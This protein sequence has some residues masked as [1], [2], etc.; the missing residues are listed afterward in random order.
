MRILPIIMKFAPNWTKNKAMVDEE[1]VLTAEN[2][3]VSYGGKVAISKINFALPRGKILAVVGESGS[4]KSTLLKAVQGLLG[5]A[6]RITSGRIVFMG[7]DI[8][9]LTDDQRRKLAGSAGMTMIFQNAAASFCPIRTVNEQIFEAVRVHKDWNY[10]HFREKA[11]GIAKKI[12]LKDE[13]LDEYPFRL[14]GGM[15]QRAGILAAII[16]SPKLILA[17]EPTS[18]L[19]TVTQVSVAKE[20]LGLKENLGISMLIVTHHM[21][22]AYYL[23]DDILLMR[24]GKMVEYGEKK[25]IFRAPK[26]EYTKELIAA[27]PRLHDFDYE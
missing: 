12:N 19:D 15:G 1:N 21:G 3:S 18:A 10:A 16:L 7:R 22:V 24:R 5:K 9:N 14:S 26:A 4:G 2:L 25:S 17:D 27:V 23:A 13:A 6:G 11:Q 20:L 8:T